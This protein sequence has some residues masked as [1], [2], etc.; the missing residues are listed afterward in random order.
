MEKLG[1]LMRAKSRVRRPMEFARRGGRFKPRADSH[2]LEAG[3]ETAP[4]VE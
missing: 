3:G 2:K 1:A 4:C